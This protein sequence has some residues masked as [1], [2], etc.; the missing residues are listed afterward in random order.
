MSF[1]WTVLCEA[2]PASEA[3]NTVSEGGSWRMK[4]PT[5]RTCSEGTRGRGSSS[6]GT[7]ELLPRPLQHPR[8][9][10]R[11]GDREPA[12]QALSLSTGSGRIPHSAKLNVTKGDYGVWGEAPVV[13]DLGFRGEAP[14][15]P[16]GYEVVCRVC[17][18]GTEE[19]SP[20]WTHTTHHP[21][22]TRDLQS[23]KFRAFQVN[24]L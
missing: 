16:K 4:D 7:K 6:W 1:Q 3:V 14:H 10:S 18:G 8:L 9:R 13:G 20:D 19:W 2:K 21:I 5:E 24:I 12:K 22:Y 17:E 23:S 15:I 11:P